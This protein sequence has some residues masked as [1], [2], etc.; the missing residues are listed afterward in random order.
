MKSFMRGVEPFVL[1][2]ESAEAGRPGE[3]ALDHPAARQQHK[4]AFRHGVFVHFEPD[5]VV[6]GGLRHGRPGVALIDISHLDR[7]S[8]GLLHV[9]WPAPQPGRDRPHRPGSPIA[10]A[11]GPACRRRCEPSSPCAVSLRRSRAARRSRAWI[12]TCGCRYTRPS[13]CPCDRR[14]RAAECACFRAETRHTVMHRHCTVVSAPYGVGNVIHDACH[15]AR[16]A[17]CT[18]ANCSG[19]I[20]CARTQDL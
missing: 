18:S 3:A 4:P 7:A 2:H 6:L 1:A 9:F 20:C 5:A 11:G 16:S 13:A 17:S 14:T 19:R 10:Q 8:G 12:A 15:S